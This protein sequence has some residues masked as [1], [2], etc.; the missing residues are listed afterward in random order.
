MNI[1]QNQEEYI[2]MKKI[3]IC[4]LTAGMLLSVTGCSFLKEAAS[5]AKN[6]L[7]SHAQQG[8]SGKGEESKEP[9][10]YEGGIGDTMRTCF[11][12]F[13]VR[14]ASL[15]ETY[16]GKTPADGYIFLDAV[17]TVKNNVY[18]DDLPMFNSDFEVV[19][20]NGDE[21]Y[22]YGRVDLDD[23]IMPEEFS[24]KKGATETYHVVYE[25]P[26]EVTQFIIAYV[27]IYEDETVGNTHG[28]YFE[29]N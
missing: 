21:D 20:G 17:I 24:M 18:G 14:S 23:S 19:W 7:E 6:I 11:F 4:C 8:E 5:A 26:K 28:V 29:I 25:V 2:R 9:Q 22:N 12:T 15:K 16:A 10:Y 3:L 13:I 1:K 27:E